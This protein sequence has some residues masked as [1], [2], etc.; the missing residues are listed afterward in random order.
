MARRTYRAEIE[1][2]APASK[3]WSILVDLDG[4][5]AWN[6]FTTRMRSTL[7]IGAPMDMRVRMSRWHLTI[8]QRE[9]VREVTAPE[10]ERAGRLVWGATMPGVVAER[11]QTL[12]PLGPSRC[13][14]LTEDTL[15]GPLERLVLA[16]F[17][18]SLDDG[19]AGVAEGLKRRAESR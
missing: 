1:I 9:T 18:G 4:Y 17:G 8:A 14:Y 13:R 16:L 10:G 19:F 6:P 3:V 2:D 12:T 5:P 11:V 15:E 7:A